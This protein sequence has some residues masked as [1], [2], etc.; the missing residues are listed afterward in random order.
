VLDVCTGDWWI[1]SLAFSPDGR[2]LLC[3]RRSGGGVAL[4]LPDGAARFIFPMH[5][6]SV[7]SLT[8]SPDGRLIASTS[9][10]KTARLWNAADFSPA[11]TL[12]LHDDFLICAAFSPDGSRLATAGADRFV[13]LWDVATRT[14]LTSLVAPNG[15][16]N[17]V[18][19][20]GDGTL[21]SCG[22]HSIDG[23]NTW[24][25]TGPRMVRETAVSLSEQVRGF[26]C[27]EDGESGAVLHPD[28]RVSVWRLSG[29]GRRT[30]YLG[31]LDRTSAA[32]S[33]SGRIVVT[34]DQAGVVRFFETDTGRP[35]AALPA[36]KGRSR[37]IKFQPGGTL[38]A[39]AGSDNFLRLW[40]MTTGRLV[41]EFDDCHDVSAD[42]A[43]FSPD[44]TRIAYC[45]LSNRFRVRRIAD[46]ELIAETP[47]SR[48]EV[49]SVRYSPDGATLAT[50]RR[51]AFVEL[52]DATTLEARARIPINAGQPWTTTFSPDGAKLFVCGWHE[53]VL[54]FDIATS[55]IERALEGHFALVPSVA[56]VKTPDP[57]LPVLLA[58]ASTDGDV[59]LWDYRSGRCLASFQPAPGWE[60][61]SVAFDASGRRLV[62]G[63]TLGGAAAWDL[64][65]LQRVVAGNAQTAIDHQHA[66]GVQPAGERTLLDWADRVFAGATSPP[67]ATDRF[68]PALIRAW[69]G[70][71]APA[72]RQEIEPP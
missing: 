57:E 68:D 13:R 37:S 63:H 5:R 64:I 29:T 60:A 66:A 7:N 20:T 15:T 58:S 34:S 41:R 32:V 47:G 14:P 30:D 50:V 61:I 3:G 62:A 46:G 16:I 4:S 6:T 67:P 44:G 1:E 69:S 38:L 43:D 54:V 12:T 71:E 72:P 56:L 36:H 35:L 52:R 2:M 18:A 11:G 51:E 21:Y 24:P 26:A 33:P 48:A 8:Y 55:T 39:T 31:G 9:P 40:D 45:G 25:V 70:P 65:E 28:G 10:D 22:W 27:G 42:S 53:T 49:L 17:T 23:W 19:W 59:R